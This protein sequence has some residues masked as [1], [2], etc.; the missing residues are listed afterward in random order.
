MKEKQEYQ[1]V[2]VKFQP[3]TGFDDEIYKGKKT[4][5]VLLENRFEYNVDYT[6]KVKIAFI[7]DNEQSEP[8]EQDNF[9]KEDGAIDK[10][11]IKA[12]VKYIDTE[13]TPVTGEPV[14][15]YK[16]DVAYGVG[17]LTLCMSTEEEQS[18]LYNEIYNWKYEG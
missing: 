13:Y 12:F 9:C 17:I 7:R 10:D 2:I 1:P 15:V 8:V 18:K 4:R 16:V 6:Q 14:K 3:W 11:I 5:V